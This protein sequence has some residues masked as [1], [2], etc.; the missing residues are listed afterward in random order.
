MTSP[1]DR[2][3]YWN[4][5]Y[6]AEG[7]VWGVEPNRFIAAE[8]AGLS[9]RR[10][11]DLGC[12]QGRNAVWLALQGHTVTGVD[13]SDVAISQAQHTAAAAGAQ[14]EFLARD[15]TTW[16][17]EPAGY[18]LVVLSYLQLPE[19]TRRQVHATAAAALAPGGRVFLIAH[20][21]DNLE[22]GIGGP[23]TTDVLS[24]EA[25]LAADFAGLDIIRN[26]VV[27]RPVVTDAASGEAI[28]ILFIAEKPAD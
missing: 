17:P 8:L 28:D 10:V 20:H 14:V 13:L 9:P 11:L 25:S 22:K 7:E 16:Q 23:Q 2:R 26:E 1:P 15:V 12:G 21:H 19:P 27:M 24:D 3:A 5:R 18:D 6:I 4:Q